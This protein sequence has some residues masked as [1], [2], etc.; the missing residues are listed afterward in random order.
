MG[1][2]NGFK[3]RDLFCIVI[4]QNDITRQLPFFTDVQLFTFIKKANC[5]RTFTPIRNNVQ[6]LSKV[7]CL[8]FVRQLFNHNEIF[9]KCTDVNISLKL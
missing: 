4:A 9:R 5:I 7:Y 8:R 3:Y 1:L 2:D 6:D